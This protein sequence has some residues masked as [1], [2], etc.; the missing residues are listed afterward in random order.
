MKIVGTRNFPW[1]A[2]AGLL[3]AIDVRAEDLR[4]YFPSEAGSTWLYSLVKQKTI[5]TG[6]IAKPSKI[7]GR[8]EEE[9]IGKS[10]LSTS[11]MPLIA[12]RRIERDGEATSG[13]IRLGS[14]LH[15]ATSADEI[16]LHA[17]E[18]KT[19]RE[20]QQWLRPPDPIL[21]NSLPTPSA[22]TII[23]S[24]RSAK[25][26][27]SSSKGH[28]VVPAGDFEDCL[29][30]T[31]GGTLTGSLNGMPLSQGHLEIKSWYV[32]GVG[33]VREERTTNSS[34]VLQRDPRSY[35]TTGPQSLS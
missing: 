27:Q 30:V 34:S 24:F 11:D 35:S 32:R 12:F 3:I 18:E 22:D 21:S 17:V 29:L 23:G 20:T 26:L 1:L 7:L 25:R 16:A 31:G 28:A 33:L 14:L 9:A 19:P 15:Y 8:L 5:T 4:T 6:G 2:I 13:K 10:S